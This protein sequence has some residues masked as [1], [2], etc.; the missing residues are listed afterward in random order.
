MSV[1]HWTTDLIHTE[2]GFNL[3][4]CKDFFFSNYSISGM[5][6]VFTCIR[7][8]NTEITLSIFHLIKHSVYTD[9]AFTPHFLRNL[10]YYYSVFWRYSLFFYIL[11]MNTNIILSS[12][13]Q[14]THLMCREFAVPCIVVNNLYLFH[15]SVFSRYSLFFSILE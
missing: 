4:F 6:S 10:Y 11:S 12:F 7:D 8:N 14:I 2:L 5:Y 1:F 13:H 9:I 15:Y 3:Y